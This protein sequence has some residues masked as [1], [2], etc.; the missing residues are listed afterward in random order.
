ML[1]L[2]LRNNYKRTESSFANILIS[3]RFNPAESLSSAMARLHLAVAV[4]SASFALLVVFQLLSSFG[5]P[6]LEFL[7]GRPESPLEHSALHQVPIKTPSV[8]PD[9]RE[10]GTRYLLGVGK[11]DITG[12]DFEHH[13]QT[14]L[15]VHRQASR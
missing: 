7:D 11:A 4:A 15:N 6:Q 14:L 8:K 1:Y 9:S 5:L 13:G 2:Y 12:Y 10:D 3:I